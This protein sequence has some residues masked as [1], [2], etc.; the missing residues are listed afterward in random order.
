MCS[1]RDFVFPF[2]FPTINKLVYVDFGCKVQTIEM[3]L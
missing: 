1:D 2:I 3:R